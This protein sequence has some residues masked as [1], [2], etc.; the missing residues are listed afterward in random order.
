M[1]NISSRIKADWKDI[2][3]ALRLDKRIGE[4][5]YIEPGLGLS[6]GNLERDLKNITNFTNDN[7]L[8]N[9]YFDN[10]IKI[11]NKKKSFPI[12]KYEI[13]EKKYGLPKKISVL[14]VVYKDGTNSYKNSP[15]I[16]LLK[17]LKKENNIYV[18]DRYVEKIN[19]FSNNIFTKSLKEAIKETE[20]IF[21]MSPLKEFKDLNNIFITDLL[22][23]KL[24]I[25]P[26]RV[27]TERSIIRKKNYFYN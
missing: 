11:N 20:V 18:Y 27:I 22:N 12:T 23:S 6:G 15:T 9:N 14:G 26:F 16:E 24:I 5:S 21:I 2:T 10:L 13:Y 3:L 19:G 4:F 25:D 17:Y 7:K 1:D 8:E